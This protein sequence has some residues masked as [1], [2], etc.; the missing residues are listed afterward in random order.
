MNKPFLLLESCVDTFSGYGKLS[1]ALARCLINLDRWDIKIISLPWG[2][3]QTGAL[4]V[5][6]PQDKS[7]MDRIISNPNLNK[8]PDIHMQVT[9]PN[10]W[11]P[12]GKF[13]IGVTAGIETTK[14][15]LDWMRGV[16]KMNLVLS[17]SKHATTVF[18]NSKHIDKNGT[19][20]SLNAPIETLFIGPK[21]VCV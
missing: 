9:V 14:A 17:T 3:C 5:S 12:L 21:S 6:N 20:I 4:D 1:R 18:E 7:I 8:Q 19:N 15:S 13:S 10:E 11:R 16:N 2:G